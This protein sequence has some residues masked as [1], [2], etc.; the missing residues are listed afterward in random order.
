MAESGFRLWFG[1]RPASEAELGHVEEIVVEQEMDAAWEARVK[2]A[3]CLDEQ[4]RWRRGPDEFNASFSRL[5][6]ELVVDGTVTALIDGSIVGEET[7]LDSQPGRSTLTLVV[8][9]DR[10][11]LDREE[12]VEVNESATER[13]LATQ[14]YDGL[15]TAQRPHR[16]QTPG[17]DTARVRVRRGTPMA[18][19]AGLAQARGWHAYVLPGDAPGQSIACYLPDPSGPATLAPL[20]LMGSARSLADLRVNRDGAGPERTVAHTQSE[21]GSSLEA[22]DTG[23]QE[24]ALLRDFPAVPLEQR[25]TRLLPPGENL[26]GAAATRAEARTTRAAGAYHLSAR[27]VPSCYSAVLTPYNKVAIRAGDSPLSGD[28][29]LTKVRHRITP[30]LHTQEIEARSDSRSDPAAPADP[31]GGPGGLSLEFSASLALV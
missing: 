29:L 2:L 16:I 18:F 30:S 14:I 5:R 15:I 13:S 6:V 4:G 21:D 26:P 8:H 7:D 3:L 1:A 12:A 28:W 31:A 19:L 25:A 17:D 9:D 27:V 22:T 23:T 11:L 24:G 10:F 20:V